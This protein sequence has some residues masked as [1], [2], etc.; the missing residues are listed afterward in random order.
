VK[1]KKK[2]T[3]LH[4]VC[5]TLVVLDDGFALLFLVLCICLFGCTTVHLFELWTNF[6]RYLF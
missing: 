2:L 3:M 5:L 4:E 6:F 1:Q